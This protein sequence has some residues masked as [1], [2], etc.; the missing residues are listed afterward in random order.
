MMLKRPMPDWLA[1]LYGEM[2][3]PPHF[4]QLSSQQ[5]QPA[6]H[7]DEPQHSTPISHA[8]SNHAVKKTAPSSSHGTRTDNF[9]PVSEHR[10]EP[11]TRNPGKAN[12]TARAGEPIK[13]ASTRVPMRTTYTPIPQAVLDKFPFTVERREQLPGILRVETPDKKRYALKK[14]ELSPQHVRFIHRALQYAQKQGFTR[15][16]RFALTKKKGPVL[17]HDDKV[18]YATEWI[19]GQHVNFAS[20]EHVAQTAYA[21]AQFHEATRGLTSEKYTP[22]DAFELFTM[23]QQRNRDLQKM[24]HRA[25][26]KD[27]KDRFDSLFVSLKEQLLED[28]AQ[29]LQLLQQSESVAFLSEDRAHAGLCHLDVIPGNCI[30]TP[31]H[32][33]HLIDFELSTFAPRA[34]DVAHLLRRSLQLTNWNGDVAYACFLHYNAVKTMPKVEYALVSALLY[35]PYRAWRLAHTRYH[36]FADDAQIDELYA[37]KNQEARRHQF[38][39]SLTEQVQGLSTT[40]V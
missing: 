27:D 11:P 35:F 39:T 38:L 30:Y 16:S 23:T 17:M 18:Y 3:K 1:Y 28:A 37:Y 31:D 19:D 15:F 33:V 14:T 8:S 9:I 29:S 32:N 21:L 6:D 26:A 36:F 10:S 25:E 40:E 2:T 34:L 20:T 5:K 22:P 4:L 12:S 13:T 24:L 7:A